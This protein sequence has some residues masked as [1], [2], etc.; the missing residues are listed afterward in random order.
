VTTDL[1]SRQ[2]AARILGCSVAVVDHLMTVGLLARVVLA[3]RYVRVPRRQVLALK[4]C[5]PLTLSQ[6]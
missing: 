2:E 6:A 4:G 1:V 3:G 5:D